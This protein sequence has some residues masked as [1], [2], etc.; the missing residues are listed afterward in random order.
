[1]QRISVSYTNKNK[2]MNTTEKLRNFFNSKLIK[3]T[4]EVENEWNDEPKLRIS[5]TVQ[6]DER[7]SFNETFLNAHKQLNNK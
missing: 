5:K 6:P 7:L 3:E 2:T 4:K 1:M